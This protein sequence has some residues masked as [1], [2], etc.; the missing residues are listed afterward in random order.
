[1]TSNPTTSVAPP[2]AASRLLERLVEG[3]ES[4]DGAAEALQPAAEVARGRG[5]WRRVVTGEVL[6]HAA[7]PLMTDLPI[8]FFSSAAL[9]DLAGGAA[10]RDAARRLV[11]AGLLAA[12]GAA[13]TGLA[14]YAPLGAR[15]KRVAATHAAL[16]TASLGLYAASW[17]LR[18]RN[19]RAGVVFG[20]AGLAV[21][22]LSA[23]LGG[24]LAIGE[25]V[26]TA[27][28]V[29]EAGIPQVVDAL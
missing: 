9:L 2:S 5:L 26:G 3:R 10:G 4:L 27:A 29:E 7:H 28:P 12:P 24:H 16:N 18:P 8:G 25:K 13:L 15:P 23:Y 22:G 1:M 14:E 6:G 21:S 20:M 11:G 17:A 19:H